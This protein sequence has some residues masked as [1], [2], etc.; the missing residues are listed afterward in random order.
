MRTLQQSKLRV[1][2][3]RQKLDEFETVIKD[4]WQ[5][6]LKVVADNRDANPRDPY[7]EFR[8]QLLD[9]GTRVMS[10]LA[11]HARCALDY[12][13]FVLAWND[14][15]QEQDGTQFPINDT[16]QDFERNRGG[17]LKHLTDEHVTEI[18]K[19]QP[20]N[21]PNS[22]LPF[23]KRISNI[24]KHREFIRFETFGEI[25]TPITETERGGTTEVNVDV[26]RAIYVLLRDGSNVHDA[27]KALAEIVSQIQEI[28]D[29]F[30]SIIR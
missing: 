25:G 5:T 14:T 16:S 1:D 15:G 23:L 17:S 11:L 6:A 18:E 21:R 30:D 22:R 8:K 24:D 19:F 29:H 26:Y 4:S 27:R 7:F 13:V 2:W 20:Y 12:I 10:E 9:P 3:A 28:V